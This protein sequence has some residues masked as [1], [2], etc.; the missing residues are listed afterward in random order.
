MNAKM[1]LLTDTDPAEQSCTKK[2]S[3]NNS[4][5]IKDQRHTSKIMTT[6]E[7]IL[8]ID[9]AVRI[10]NLLN[11]KISKIQSS[12]HRKMSPKNMLKLKITNSR[13]LKSNKKIKLTNKANIQIVLHP[14]HQA[15]LQALL[16]V[17]L[18]LT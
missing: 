15:P 17:H 4:I 9:Q 6:N 10:S 16:Q 8:R 12:L 5:R 7:D 1:K 2:N 3:S 11:N 18:I 13:K 14:L